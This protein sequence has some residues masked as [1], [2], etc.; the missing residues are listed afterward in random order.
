VGAVLVGF[1]LLKL[2]YYAWI[3]FEIQA[4]LAGLIFLYYSFSNPVLFYFF[5]PME[6]V[7]FVASLGCFVLLGF[8]FT[9]RDQF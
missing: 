9:F 6:F 1:R 5:I 3:V 2:N 8:A 7:Y 4:G